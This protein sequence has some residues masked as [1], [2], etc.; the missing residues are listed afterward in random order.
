MKKIIRKNTFETNS[1]S[2]HS[3]CIAKSGRTKSKFRLNKDGK[4]VVHLGEFGKNYCIYDSQHDK[5]SYLM[6]CLYYLNGYEVENIYDDW[7]F[8]Y[9]EEVICEYANAKGIKILVDKNI[10]PYID[11]QS[12][13]DSHIEIINTYDKD[14]IID[15]VFN[16]Y[17]SLKTDWD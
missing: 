9:I 14:S 4:I 12:V 16:E 11:H 6:T 1:S 13:P 17:V 10:E 5:L 7:T 3:L 8:K 2:T 15:F